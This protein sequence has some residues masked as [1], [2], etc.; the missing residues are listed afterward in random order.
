MP[1]FPLL[2]MAILAYLILSSPAY[3][4]GSYAIRPS[5]IPFDIYLIVTLYENLVSFIYYTVLLYMNYTIP[6]PYLVNILYHAMAS[7]FILS[8]KSERRGIVP[9][10]PFYSTTFH[11]LSPRSGMLSFTTHSNALVVGYVWIFGRGGE[12]RRLEGVFSSW[13]GRRSVAR[14]GREWIGIDGLGVGY[15]GKV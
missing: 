5:C 7:H 10:I 2:P 8:Y 6:L 1:I 15:E 13:N 12:G 3:L 11:I 9:Y 4:I 14:R